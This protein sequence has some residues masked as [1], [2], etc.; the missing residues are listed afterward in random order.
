MGVIGSSPT[1]PTKVKGA[2]ESKAPFALVIFRK[3]RTYDTHD[4]GGKREKRQPSGLSDR[5]GSDSSLLARK[6]A[7][8]PLHGFCATIER[9]EHRFDN[10]IVVYTLFYHPGTFAIRMND[11]QQVFRYNIRYKY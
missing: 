5:V 9:T 11:L 3:D 7:Q 8:S 4:R 1:N 10:S 6:R 2:C